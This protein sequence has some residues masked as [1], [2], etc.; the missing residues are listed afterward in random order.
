MWAYKSVIVLA[1]W[2]MN[3]VKSSEKLEKTEGLVK[4]KNYT[5]YLS[6]KDDTFYLFRDKSTIFSKIT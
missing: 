3:F 4:S 1:K 2:V 6:K 5:V